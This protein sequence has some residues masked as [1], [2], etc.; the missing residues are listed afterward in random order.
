M[1]NTITSPTHRQTSE[2]ITLKNDRWML[3][4]LRIITLNVF[5]ANTK[6]RKTQQNM[7]QL[8]REYDVICLQETHFTSPQKEDQFIYDIKAFDPKAAVICTTRNN[9]KCTQV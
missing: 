5:G 1:S 2:S 6:T 4:R 9:Y 8:L 3:P 7:K